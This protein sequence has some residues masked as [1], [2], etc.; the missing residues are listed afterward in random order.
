MAGGQSSQKV[1]DNTTPL[2]LNAHA[3]YFPDLTSY[4][5]ACKTDPEL[6]AFDN[7]L[8]ER[9]SRVINSLAVGV[10]VRSLSLD[11]L[12]EVTT[13][14]LEMNQEVVKVILECKKDIW[15]N[16]DLFALVEDYFE[17][18]LQ[19][20]DFCTAL[21]KCLK[22]AID[23]QL[24]IQFA[25]RQFEEE[26]E[27]GTEGRKYART[28][29]EL[30]KFKAAGDPFTEEFFTIFQSVYKHQMVMLERLQVQR[31]KLD[32]K[33]KSAKTWM[34]VTNVIFVA[35][36]VS[37]LIIS[38]VA[39]AITLPPVVT[40]LAGALTAPVGSVGKWCDSLWKNYQNA[41]KGQRE[42]ITSMQVGTYVTIK[43]MDS[44]RILV[45]R[46][47]IEIESAMRKVDIAMHDDDAL[48]FAMEE[49][50]KKLKVFVEDVDGLGEYADKC[51]REIR[52]AR[53]VVLQRII[54]SPTPTP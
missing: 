1:E 18:S 50:K 48:K 20:L 9:T 25:V 34:R 13:S 27:G 53:T 44:I 16:Q 2:P 23:S 52:K 26:G 43:D 6:Q 28:L 39:A 36:V 37:A 45:S 38:V 47:E 49:I 4:E 7:T 54:R 10:E 5:E 30:R 21:E 14:L 35:A 40:A 29:E 19:T 51:S 22:R 15:N 41:L 24:I 12:R 46:L 32:K 31:R 17:N 8:H 11:S 3:E 33:L 42:L